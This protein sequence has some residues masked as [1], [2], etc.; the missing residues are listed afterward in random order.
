MYT[1]SLYPGISNVSTVSTNP[2]YT[3]Q[4][5]TDSE[6]PPL[7]RKSEVLR[8]FITPRRAGTDHAVPPVRRMMAIRSKRRIAYPSILPAPFDT[9]IAVLVQP[10]KV[11]PHLFLPRFD[12]VALAEVVESR[13]Q[14]ADGID[15]EL[16]LVRLQVAELGELF[17]AIVEFAGERLDGGV[18]D[19][20][21]ANVAVLGESLATNVA[22]VWTFAR[23]PPFVSL[24][25]AELA[26]SLSARGLFAHERFDAGVC[27]SVYV[28]MGLLIE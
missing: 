15:V 5:N 28:Q 22:V 17:V 1:Y 23:V 27:S 9:F 11:L 2:T 16:V 18:Y 26:E 4:A 20:V 3:T 24:E 13:F 21:C 25:V 8:H 14:S 19:L 10:A 6:L 12:D 7:H